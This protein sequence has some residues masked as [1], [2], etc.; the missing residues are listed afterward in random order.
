MVQ[1]D[2]AIGEEATGTVHH[3]A[4]RA[5]DDPHQLDWRQAL[6]GAGRQ[7]TPVIERKYLGVLEGLAKEPAARVIDPLPGWFDRRRQTLPSAKDVLA[8]LPSGAEVT[9][10]KP[11]ASEHDARGRRRA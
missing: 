6:L 10:S 4:W 3:V 1:P 5:L 9:R 2:A 7:V 8:R 11:G